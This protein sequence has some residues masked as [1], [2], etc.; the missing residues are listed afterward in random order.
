[1]SCRRYL[2]RKAECEQ[3]LGAEA[4]EMGGFTRLLHSGQADDLMDE[5]PTFVA[6]PLPNSVVEHEAYPVLNRPYA[7]LQWIK[8][9]N[10]TEDY[11][12]MSEPDHIFLRPIPNL[13]RKDS[14][15]AAYPFFYIEPAKVRPKLV[16][17]CYRLPAASMCSS[18]SR[19]MRSVW[20]CMSGGAAV[21]L[22]Q[23][24][25]T[26]NKLSHGLDVFV[27]VL[28]VCEQALF[29]SAA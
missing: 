26:H 15:P 11:I 12:L 10:I 7:F 2:K 9:S 25:C 19:S 21:Q 6:Q 28:N 16:C 29:V 27:D 20:Y 24:C 1:L 3:Q 5:V 4:C 18:C 22:V 13:I 14:W 17:S 8:A 23:P